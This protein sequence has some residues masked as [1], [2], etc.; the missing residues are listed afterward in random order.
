MVQM[1]MI[2][3]LNRRSYWRKR[4]KFIA[5]NLNQKGEG[6]IPKPVEAAITAKTQLTPA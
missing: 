3:I 4:W 5:R 6:V 1:R 2:C